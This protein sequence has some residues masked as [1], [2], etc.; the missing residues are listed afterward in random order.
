MT[1]WTIFLAV[2]LAVSL[3]TMTTEEFCVPWNPFV[4]IAAAI[5]YPFIWVSERRLP[6]KKRTPFF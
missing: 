3:A 1:F 4:Y 5:M 2:F 6:K